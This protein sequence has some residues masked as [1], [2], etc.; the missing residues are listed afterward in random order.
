VFYV[1]EKEQKFLQCDVRNTDLPDT[2][3]IIVTEPGG[4]VR[5]QYVTGSQ[6]I[7]RQWL[8]LQEDLTAAGCW[9]PH[10]LQEG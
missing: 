7:L 9:G 1:F 5:T 6:E 10:G 2:F 8:A 4:K 3:A